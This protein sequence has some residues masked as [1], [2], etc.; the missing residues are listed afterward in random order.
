MNMIL[1]IMAVII[2]ASGLL[3]ISTCILSSQISQRDE[4][5][6]AASDVSKPAVSA[7]R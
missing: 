2:G 7:P 5:D 3:A 4:E 1:T 6:A